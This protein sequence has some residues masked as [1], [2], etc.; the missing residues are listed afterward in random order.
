MNNENNKI[1]NNNEVVNIRHN[2]LNNKITRKQEEQSNNQKNNYFDKDFIDTFSNISN[3]MM[4]T[5]ILPNII[6]IIGLLLSY[7]KK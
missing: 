3:K 1:N 2:P 7:K 6:F 5:S 4:Y